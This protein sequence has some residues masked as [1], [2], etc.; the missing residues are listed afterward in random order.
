MHYY[1]IIFCVVFGYVA[2]CCLSTPTSDY[3]LNKIFTNSSALSV[4]S[5]SFAENLTTSKW[6]EHIFGSKSVYWRDLKRDDSI[7]FIES[8]RSNVLKSEWISNLTSKSN[9][10]CSITMLGF[11]RLERFAPFRHIDRLEKDPPIGRAELRSHYHANHDVNLAEA[12]ESAWLCH[13]RA[14]YTNLRSF[15]DSPDSFWAVMLYCPNSNEPGKGKQQCSSFK[16][17]HRDNTSVNHTVTMYLRQGVELCTDIST[18]KASTFR[19]V[20]KQDCSASPN[21][22]WQSPIAVCT[23]WPF[24]SSNPEKVPINQAL[25]YEFVRYYANLGMTIF[26]YD[27][28]GAGMNGVLDGP[29]ARANPQKGRFFH[30]IQQRLIY[31]NY[32]M[33]GLLMPEED[34]ASFSHNIW[35]T[36]SDK[37]LTYTQCR[38]QALTQYG[39]ERVVV[40]DFDEFLFCKGVPPSPFEQSRFLNGYLQTLESRGTE[41]IMFG[42]TTVAARVRSSPFSATATTPATV[43]ECMHRAINNSAALARRDYLRR[44]SRNPQERSTSLFDCFASIDHIDS[45]PN[46]KSIHLQYTCPFTS[47]HQACG[48]CPPPG[49]RTGNG[50]IFCSPEEMTYW[51]Y[52]CT[53]DTVAVGRCD[54]VHLSV[55]AEKYTQQFSNVSSSDSS[56]SSSNR[57]VDV[58]RKPSEL[59]FIANAHS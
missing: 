27:R 25:I 53:C 31:H 29:Y 51:W 20:M 30:S 36:D 16:E 43:E 17:R 13:Y 58:E 48:G 10:S 57:M 44:E 41:Q 42:K 47:M 4:S 50:S 45:I 11:V 32:T 28:D 6:V 21:D 46:I 24:A 34:N 5:F 12:V 59:W 26:V 33:H 56:N 52:D 8:A 19:P 18:I 3:Q 15:E 2:F 14:L 49:G 39:I 1:A 38:F 9:A 55:M 7:Q 40:V 54:F 37:D 35:R 22:G 23:A